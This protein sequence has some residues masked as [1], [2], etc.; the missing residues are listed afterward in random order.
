MQAEAVG[1][2]ARGRS[3]IGEGKASNARASIACNGN[4]ANCVS[5]STSEEGHGR[6]A[7]PRTV[8][9]NYNPLQRPFTQCICAFPTPRLP[10]STRWTTTQCWRRLQD[11]LRMRLLEKSCP[12]SKHIGLLT[13]RKS[14][15][16]EPPSCIRCP[17]WTT[18][19]LSSS[20]LKPMTSKSLRSSTS[21][22]LNA[23]AG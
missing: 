5:I 4:S 19:A 22:I 16:S 14:S 11:S 13:M 9:L 2:L 8:G 7:L 23:T 12:F 21:T 18:T 17:T 6:S 3:G 20:G 1:I 10:K 15:G